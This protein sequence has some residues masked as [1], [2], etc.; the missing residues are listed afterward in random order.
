M[1]VFIDDDAPDFKPCERTVRLCIE[2]L[3]KDERKLF[4]GEL[5]YMG[6]VHSKA[7]YRL[8]I[9]ALQALLPDP[10]KALLAEIEDPNAATSREFTDGAYWAIKRL[11]DTGRIRSGE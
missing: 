11:F 6:L 5:G 2:A 10:A 4:P 7:I 8:H 3:P 1:Y 9:K